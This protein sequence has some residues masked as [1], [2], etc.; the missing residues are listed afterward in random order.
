MGADSLSLCCPVGMKS[1]DGGVITRAEGRCAAEAGG[2]WSGTRRQGTLTSMVETYGQEQSFL[3]CKAGNLF[4][5][6][7]EVRCGGECGLSALS[8]SPL[9]QSYLGL[10]FPIRHEEGLL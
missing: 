1:S 4:M 10:N 7:G 8:G 2:F 9:Q 5:L 6:R 3:I